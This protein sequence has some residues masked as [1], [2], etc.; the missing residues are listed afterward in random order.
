MSEKTNETNKKRHIKVTKYVYAHEANQ[1]HEIDV[2]RNYRKKDNMFYFLQRFLSQ[3][4][5]FLSL[6]FRSHSLSLLE[7]TT[8]KKICEKRE[9]NCE[10]FTQTNLGSMRVKFKHHF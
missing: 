9:E 4:H 2:K 3:L 6:R 5:F 7:E 1:K 8:A 10:L